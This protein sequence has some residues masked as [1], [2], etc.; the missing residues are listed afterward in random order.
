MARKIVAMVVTLGLI[1][2]ALTGAMADGGIG[3]QLSDLNDQYQGFAGGML[4]MFFSEYET[5]SADA[6]PVYI[7]LIHGYYLMYDATEYTRLPLS[8]YSFLLL[9]GTAGFSTGTLAEAQLAVT[10]A[11][12]DQWAS[13]VKGEIDGD[14]YVQFVKDM[15][16]AT[17][18]AHDQV[19]KDL[20]K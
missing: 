3:N 15:Y 14:A 10:Q 5:A 18:N 13:Y 12:M 16:G 2:T 1:L 6:K 9:S 19:Q 11:K 7:S 17:K 4:E 20:G 8:Q